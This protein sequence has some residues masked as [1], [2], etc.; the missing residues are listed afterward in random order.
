VSARETT[1]TSEASRARRA[2]RAT[3]LLAFAL[4]VLVGPLVNQVLLRAPVR[5]LPAWRMF[6]TRA[7]GECQSE[8]LLRAADGSTTRLDRYALLDV[9][10]FRAPNDVRHLKGRTDAERLGARLCDA[11]RAT[12]DA[13]DVRLH[14]RCAEL[15]RGWNV[16]TKGETNL[17]TATLPTTDAPPRANVRRARP[18]L[19]SNARAPE[20]TP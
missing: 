12:H 10:R 20:G 9:D 7:L 3:L 2:L 19:D 1:T 4:Y 5:A 15:A 11:L 14:R 13:P 6:G 8:F 16:T 17:C 18:L